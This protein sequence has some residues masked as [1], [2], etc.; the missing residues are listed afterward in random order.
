M[1]YDL[2][3]VVLLTLLFGKIKTDRLRRLMA[4]A[5]LAA[6]PASFRAG[7]QYILVSPPTVLLGGTAQYGIV[8]VAY[9]NYALQNAACTFLETA[10][11]VTPFAPKINMGIWSSGQSITTIEDYIKTHAVQAVINYTNYTNMMSPV[12]GTQ[13]ITCSIT[14]VPPDSF[15]L[16]NPT[17]QTVAL[18]PAYAT[19][20]FPPTAQGQVICGVS[21]DGKEDMTSRWVLGAAQSDVI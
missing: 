13:T 14:V 11:N 7:A 10:P 3:L 2:P 1:D 5:F 8:L 18:L 6:F 9:G 15:N 4:T 12:N 21:A 19:F 20:R 16:P 17:S